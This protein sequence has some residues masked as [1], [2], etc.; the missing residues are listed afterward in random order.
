MTGRTWK[1]ASPAQVGQLAHRVIA[2]VLTSQGDGQRAATWREVLELVDQRMAHDGYRDR[3]ARQLVAAATLSYL[4]MAPPPPWQFVRAE[5]VLPGVRLDLVW[6]LPGTGRLMVDEVKTG[7]AGAGT[8]AARGQGLRYLH[9]IRAQDSLGVVRVLSTRAPHTN[10]LLPDDAA[11]QAPSAS[12][13][14]PTG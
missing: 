11:T 5:V 10:L 12:R 14:P 6:R 2:D 1:T 9:A 4:Q 8:G 7:H 3:A 13:G